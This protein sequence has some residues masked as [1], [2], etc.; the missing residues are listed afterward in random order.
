MPFAIKKMVVY[1][2]RYNC[3]P[4]ICNHRVKRV[5]CR[6]LVL[7]SYLL[8]FLQLRHDIFHP[9]NAKK[10]QDLLYKVELKNHR[11]KEKIWQAFSCHKRNKRQR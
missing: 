5:F 10:D 4:N 6:E 1:V 11:I 2:T 7:A 8:D 9:N 3:Q